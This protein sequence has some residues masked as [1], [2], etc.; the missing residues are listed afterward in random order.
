MVVEV[1]RIQDIEGA[2]KHK[3]KTKHRRL[4]EGWNKIQV[5][6]ANDRGMHYRVFT[7][8]TEQSG[9]PQER[10]LST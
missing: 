3:A 7:I 10:R 2:S 6:T 4:A 8:D 5:I 9:D 1:W